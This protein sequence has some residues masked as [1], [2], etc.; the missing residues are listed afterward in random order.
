VEIHRLSCESGR[1]GGG[2]VKAAEPAATAITREVIG[3][4][5]FIVG[6]HGGCEG[7]CKSL[8]IAVKSTEEITL[9]PVN[10]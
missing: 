1:R 3:P 5:R 6:L 4:G 7:N 2:A 8:S 9:F 10:I